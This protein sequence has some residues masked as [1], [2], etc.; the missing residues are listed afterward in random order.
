[1]EIVEYEHYMR[2]QRYSKSTIVSY[3][4]FVRSF[5][6][7]FKD[8]ESAYISLRDIHKYNYEVIIKNRYSISYQRQF[9]GAIKIFF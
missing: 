7:F 6:G 8:K 3:L 1:M 2:G 9:I 5:L 4:T